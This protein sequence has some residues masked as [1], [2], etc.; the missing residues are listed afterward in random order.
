MKKLIVLICA[1][2][3]MITSAGCS[4]QIAKLP[5]NTTIESNKENTEVVSS[6]SELGTTRVLLEVSSKNTKIF[7]PVLQG[8]KGELSM[9]Y[10][11]QS[12]K[13]IADFYAN[14]EE[15]MDVQ[16]DYE[17]KKLDNIT[18][19]ILFKGTG[20]FKDSQK[21][22]IQKSINLDV[23]STNPIEYANFIKNDEKSLAEV[24]EILDKKAKAKG[25][26]N[27]FEAEGVFI[28]FVGDRVVFY[29]MPLDHAATEW[30]DLSVNL[31]ELEGLINTEFGEHPAS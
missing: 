13:R 2:L 22:N 29:Y 27:G 21:I 7:Y 31:S 10:M 24:K 16:L 30:I 12:I 15:Y 14:G 1:G 23:M 18:V 5:A 28:Y 8:Y 19:S 3:L 17:V 9:D 25:I 26:N 11:N 4:Q 6:N 20:N